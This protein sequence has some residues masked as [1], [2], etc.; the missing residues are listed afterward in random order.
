MAASLK[1]H[2]G[3]EERERDKYWGLYFA[4]FLIMKEKDNN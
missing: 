3:G 2:R 4:T 1:Q